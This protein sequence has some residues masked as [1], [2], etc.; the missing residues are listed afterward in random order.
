[1]K[2]KTKSLS[3]VRIAFDEDSWLFQCAM[4]TPKWIKIISYSIFFKKFL[5]ATRAHIPRIVIV[6]LSFEIMQFCDCLNKKRKQKK[7]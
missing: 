2:T 7:Y 4:R 5:F 3:I 1:M 6:G